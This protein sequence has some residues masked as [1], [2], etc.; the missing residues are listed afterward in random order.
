MRA[1]NFFAGLIIIIVGIIFLGI[2]MGWWSASVWGEIWR[3][4]PLILILLGL[5]KL[6]RSDA[7]F[8]ILSA[9]IILATVGAILVGAVPATYTY[10]ERSW[11]RDWQFGEGEQLS[12]EMADFSTEL[13]AA[14]LN[15]LIIDV[16]HLTDITVTGQETDKVSVNLRGPKEYID[17]FSL[18]PNGTTATLKDQDRTAFR[19]SFGRDQRV[20]GTVTL[21]RAMALELKLSG[22]AKVDLRD[23]DGVL[24]IDNSG[25]T[26]V[27]S[28]N[29][30][31]KL[32]VVALSGSSK[33]ELERC[34]AEGEVRFDLSGASNLTIEQCQLPSL[35]VLTSGASKVSVESGSVGD[36]QADA[37]GA[38]KI[39]LPRP[40]GVVDQNSSGAAKIELR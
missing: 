6:I 19:W 11:S 24:L 13:N 39:T 18:S 2:T 22:V 38:S 30:P 27:T 12:G 21:P 15:R 25:A 40:T 4:W 1:G 26:E 16:G 9:L 17:D 34:Q 37:S 14:S 8:A 31:S 7:L 23:H 33:V 35:S 10:S 5:R 3:F 28:T 32:E 29:S 36:L 20:R